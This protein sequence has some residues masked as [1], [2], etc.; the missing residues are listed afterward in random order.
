[1]QR[2][3]QHVRFVPRSSEVD[4]FD[5]GR[6]AKGRWAMLLPESHSPRK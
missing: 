4:Y 3:L 5:K 6:A 2:P 1:M